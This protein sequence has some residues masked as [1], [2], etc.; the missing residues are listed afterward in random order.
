MFK[1]LV[2]GDGYIGINK[3]KNNYI[4]IN[5]VINLH[6]SEEKKL[7]DIQ[8]KLKIGRI[9]VYTKHN[10]AQYIISRTDLQEIL[11]PLILYHNLF[12]LTKTRSTQFNKKMFILENANHIK[13]KFHIEKAEKNK[14][15][16]PFINLPTN[17]ENYK[18]KVTSE[19]LKNWL[20]GFT[21]AE[22]SFYI[23]NNGDAKF[24]L[25]QREE[26]ILFD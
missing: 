21:I 22:G 5:M 11:I 16:P 6:I 2:D 23:K 19:F 9:N 26:T 1:G 3:T 17:L 12:F 15:I 18:L 14:K 7:R 4:R 24:S 20:I 8:K 25:K 13:K 10:V